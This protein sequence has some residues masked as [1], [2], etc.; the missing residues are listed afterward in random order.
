MK[1][2][3]LAIA[4]LLCLGAA[5]ARAEY[6]PETASEPRPS[7]EPRLRAD[8]PQQSAALQPARASH[9]NSASDEDASAPT[10]ARKVVSRG[11]SLWRISRITY[12]DGGR[13]ALLY[14]A[15]R[16]HIRDP[17]LIYPGQTL[18]LPAKRN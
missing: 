18:V 1:T 5:Q 6:A 13:Y 12:G 14:R 4:V 11:E 9:G 17:N 2:S 7:S 8:K 16:D 10:V 15:N 3:L